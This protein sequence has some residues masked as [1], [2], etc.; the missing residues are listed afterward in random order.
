MYRR[1]YFKEVN[2]SKTTLILTVSICREPSLLYSSQWLTVR[3]EARW[4]K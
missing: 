1:K 2:S 3:Q 4:V